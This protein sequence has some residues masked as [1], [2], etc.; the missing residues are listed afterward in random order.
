MDDVVKDAEQL[1]RTGQWA[2]A[3]SLLQRA[4]Q[5]FPASA[6]IWVLFARVLAHLREIDG[7]GIAIENAIS[8][9]PADGQ[10]RLLAARIFHDAGKSARSL[11]HAYQVPRHDSA[12]APA[13]HQAGLLLADL[14]RNDDAAEA[15]QA[16]V[17]AQPGY[18]RALGNLASMRLKQRRVDDAIAA[19]DAALAVQPG[20]AH[21]HYIH[22][23]AH[24]LAGR[25]QEALH[26]LETVL[27]N[28]PGYADAWLMMSR[29]HRQQA[30][31][32]A[33]VGCGSKVTAN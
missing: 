28:D 9:A 4:S 20:Y 1:I 10:S 31:N 23:S 19:A 8:L 16:A 5:Q 13:R 6:S 2:D 3:R 12:Y 18:V 27:T 30:G 7:A 33:S 25:V 17:D 26:S 11:E 21:A 15:F 24:L 14:Q 29:I 22:A 32:R